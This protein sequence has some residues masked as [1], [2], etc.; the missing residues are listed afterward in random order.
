MTR[1]GAQQIF[2][3]AADVEAG[4]G[5]D[6]GHASHDQAGTD[7]AQ[8]A[9]DGMERLALDQPGDGRPVPLAGQVLGDVQMGLVDPG[10]A[11]VDQLLVELLLFLEAE[12]LALLLGQ[13]LGNLVEGDV[14]VCGSNA[15]TTCRVA[16]ARSARTKV[17]I[18]TPYEI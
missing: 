9:V 7:L 13:A 1:G 12:D 8:V 18:S 14:V 10:D 16:L 11:L 6:A 2:R 17:V 4:V 5:V 15:G 3:A